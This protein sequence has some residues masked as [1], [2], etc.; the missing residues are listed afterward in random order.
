MTIAKNATSKLFVAM[1]A[2]AMVFM[3][4]NPAKAAT[5]EALQAQIDALMAQISGLQGGG[6]AMTHTSACTFTRPLTVGSQGADVKC[7]QDAMTPMYFNNAGGST[8]YFGPVTQAAVAKWQAANGVMPAAGYFGPIS[9]AKFAS[10]A[11]TTGGGD[12][13]TT[14]DDTPT[15][16]DLS[17]DASL[18]TFTAKSG[19]D[20]NLEEAQKDAPVA[21]LDIKFN[22]GD[23]R[24]T[25]MDVVL[26]P[27]SSN[28][29][30]KAWKTFDT[31]SLWVDGEKVADVDASQ[32]SEYLDDSLAGNAA[33]LR[34]SGLDIVAKQ[35]KKMTVSIGV[36][37]QNSVDGTA[38]GEA[39][40]VYVDSLRYIDGSDVTTT[41]DSFQDV[42]T[43]G[44][45]SFDINSEG[46]DDELTVKSASS[47][48]DSTT[49]KLK[50]DKK[51]DWMKVF[52]FDLDTK[53]STNDILLN[54][55]FVNVNVSSSSYNSMVNDAQLVIGGK[56]Y[57][58]V[59][60]VGGTTATGQ[61]DFDLTDDDVTINA[62]DKVTATLELRF[63]ALVLGNEGTQVFA[64]TTGSTLDAEGA[65][66]LTTT[67]NQL[68]G[69]A[70]G[71]T[72]T[73]RTS[74]VVLELKDTTETLKVNA[75]DVTTDDQ[76]VFVLKF[77]VT[78]FEDSIWINKSA[79]SGT[80]MGTAGANFIVLDSNGAQIGAGT[81]TASLAS[82]ATTDGTRFLVNE[83]DTETFT[84][85]VNYDP[86]TV[87]N[88]F[89]VR[90]Y[91]LN[92]AISNAAPTTQQLALPT[93]NFQTD[94]LSI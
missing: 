19:D 63:S 78:A 17:G 58:N 20:T 27:G 92:S 94:Q 25:R 75:T 4:A 71:D 2:A 51:S 9:Q 21:D 55:V 18:Q 49:F 76:G 62:G 33:S 88:F 87:G 26:D 29:V 89:Q 67:N 46:G 47:D 6:A 44:T 60:V 8:G 84:L 43:D 7:L 10:M 13:P 52:A 61:L 45:V 79:A 38:N 59:T 30:L 28:D 40:T 34:F 83:G 90:L 56:T 22:N 91:S 70:T 69:S 64:S 54:H 85:T 12:T 53:N 82:T 3:L 93:A 41:E 57:D 74:G 65:D 48:P 36:T 16:G 68:S 14:G 11:P 81:S 23:A 24:I 37:V 39:W 73:L 5:A 35:D 42:G 1:V 31:V 15:T 80:T 50:N 72:H 77:D 32:K 66:T 86:A